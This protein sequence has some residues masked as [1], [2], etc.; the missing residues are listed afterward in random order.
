MRSWFLGMLLGLV[1]CATS[2]SGEREAPAS[3]S[4]AVAAVAPA[5]RANVPRVVRGNLTTEL[6]PEL[7]PEAQARLTRYL[8]VRRADIAGWDAGGSG[9]FVLTRLANVQQ[10]HRVDMPL[11]MRRQLTFGNEGVDGFAAS[12]EATSAAG[13]LIADV[14]GS[15]DTQLYLLDARGE[16]RLITDG[17]SRNEAPVWAEDGSRIAFSS[18][19][20]NARDF[21]LWVYDATRPDAP[22]TLAY[23][24]SGQ[25]RA[26]DWS[27]AGDALLASHFISETKSEL[28]VVVPGRG[29]V[30]EFRVAEPGVDVAFEDGV[31][32]PDGKG[33][34]YLSDHGGEHRALWY[35]DLASGQS[36]RLSS[37]VP[38]DYEQLR[39]TRDRKLL[40]LTLNEAGWSKLSLYDVAAQRFRAEP[41]LPPAVINRLAF[42]RDGRRLALTLQGGRALGD[43]YVLDLEPARPALTRWTE[44]E[45]GGLD[46][47]RLH[48]PRLIEYASFDGRPIPALVF[49]PEGAG[50]HPV[51]IQ[52]HG[53]PEGQ[54][55]PY[56]NPT[57]EYLL[58]ELG[59]AVVLPNVRGSTGY[60][61][62]YTLLD[63]GE[64]REDS[65]KD[66]GAL[67]DWIATQPRFDARRVA[68]Y[69][70][71]YGG[72]MSLAT[73][74]MFGSRVAAV[75]DMVGISN[76][77]SFLESTKEYRRDLRRVEYGDERVPEMRSFLERISPLTNSQKI[78]APLFVAQGKNDPRVPL[79]EAEQIVEKVRAQGREVWYM[80]AA[81]EGH[82][83]QKK[84]NRDAFTAATVAFYERHLAVR[85]PE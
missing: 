7:G 14:G 4:S 26:L 69:G 58:S 8:D 18:T 77:V 51:V 57:N 35:R 74:A 49:E 55:R 25:W 83:F 67:L 47:A 53:G 38:W 19:R 33:V 39:A 15:E 75:V 44:S 45:L 34:Y 80:L 24:A 21:D 29:V 3:E 9:L 11:G 22:P 30:H 64:R 23:E 66:I 5:A 27:P 70:G 76:F 60:G 73:G 6:V 37:D 52:I 68:V 2:G 54:S 32:G 50:P 59:I 63:N 78:V 84:V 31:F 20:R 61:R 12:P 71:S 72:F 41:E 56:L 81:D 42:S 10:L 65:V 62:A 82:G 28:S 79:S 40:A 36:R 85:K 43:V 1:A 17:K 16:Q 13:I 46:A 48:Q